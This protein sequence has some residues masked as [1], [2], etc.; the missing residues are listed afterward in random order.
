M[1]TDATVATAL[2]AIAGDPRFEVLVNSRKYWQVGNYD[3]ILRR[4]EIADEDVVVTVDGDDWLPDDPHI[5]QRISQW[6]TD[7]DLWTT[8]GNSRIEPPRAG[9]VTGSRPLADVS[10]V[11]R[12]EWFVG[13]L[14]TF[15]AFLWRAIRPEDLRWVGG[16]YV[17]VSGDRACFCPMLEMAG[18]AHARF[19]DEINYVYNDSN[20]IS[21]HRVN[22]QL[23]ATIT[24]HV[25]AQP[26]YSP[27]VRG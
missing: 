10:Q 5:L 20:P 14:H 8:W 7:P 13:H 15:R 2:A 25:H 18:N 22:S 9:W 23:Q 12:A 24:A 4:E 3:Q 6:Y 11:R 16:W 21:D 26:P 1:S 19:I 27:L 17:P